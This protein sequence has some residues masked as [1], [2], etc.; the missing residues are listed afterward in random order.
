MPSK[1]DTPDDPPQD[2]APEAHP[3]RR[4]LRVCMGMTALAG[5]N[6]SLLAA[7][8][9]QRNDEGR[10]Y[11]R[12]VLVDEQGAPLR[13]TTLKAG[14][15]YV[16][17][18]PYVSTP[19][20]LLNLGESVEGGQRLATEDGRHYTWHGGVGPGRAI[21][22]FSAIC[23]HRMSYPAREVSFINYRHGPTDFVDGQARPAVQERVIFC[24]S[25]RS[26]YDAAKGA[27]V[28]GGPATQP[29][30]AIRLEHDPESDAL[31]AIGA[32]GGTLFDSFVRRFRHQLALEYG[33]DAVAMPVTQR[34]TVLPLDAFTKNQV[35]C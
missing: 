22:A 18:Y 23:A 17:P 8:K 35:L 15:N 10:D 5:A 13:A 24:C 3:R 20:F 27:R 34:S 32:Q 30:A 16:F 4:F 11:A 28:L 29:L 6:P 33:A 12:V 14:F 21:V 31:F 25:E 7:S 19:C 2:A 26:V 9:D 1:K